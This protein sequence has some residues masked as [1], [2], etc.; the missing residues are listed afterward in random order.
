MSANP[1]NYDPSLV[2]AIVIDS[3]GFVVSDDYLEEFYNDLKDDPDMDGSVLLVTGSAIPVSQSSRED[4]IHRGASSYLSQDL[5]A[6]HDLYGMPVADV[7]VLVGR[8]RALA[9]GTVGTL[10]SRAG[11]S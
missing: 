4:D 8:L 3:D 6:E 5:L 9:T 1:S 10:S 11:A 2:Y 7:R